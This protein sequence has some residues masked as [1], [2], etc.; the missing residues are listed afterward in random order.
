MAGAQHWVEAIR[1]RRRP[2]WVHR[3]V[4]GDAMVAAPEDERRT[5]QGLATGVWVVLEEPMTLERIVADLK[6]LGDVPDDVA[7]LVRSA[8]KLLAEHGVVEQVP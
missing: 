4:R 5:L 3:E 8:L 6:D 1:W 2:D 7:A